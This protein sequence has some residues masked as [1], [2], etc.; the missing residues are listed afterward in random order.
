MLLHVHSPMCQK[1]PEVPV[2]EISC[3]YGL[4]HGLPVSVR[5]GDCNAPLLVLMLGT[6]FGRVRGSARCCACLWCEGGPHRRGRVS[7]KKNMLDSMAVK[8]T[9]ASAKQGSRKGLR[10]SS[11]GVRRQGS[12]TSTIV[13]HGAEKG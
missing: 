8:E 11:T 3:A 4:P 2:G 12:I 9:A 5:K 6:G 10:A 7:F 13:R 1:Q